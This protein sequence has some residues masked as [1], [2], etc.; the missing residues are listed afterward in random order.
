MFFKSSVPSHGLCLRIQEQLLYTKEP[1]ARRGWTDRPT[2]RPTHRR[3]PP[4]PAR[5]A[6]KGGVGGR[7]GWPPPPPPPARGA[8]GAGQRDVTA[9]PRLPGRGQLPRS[10]GNG[11]AP[12][13]AGCGAR[14]ELPKEPAPRWQRSS[15]G[16]SGA[17]APPRPAA[18]AP[19]AAR[20][21]AAA[22]GGRCGLRAARRCS[23]ARAGGGAGSE[24]LPALPAHGCPRSRKVLG[25]ERAPLPP[26]LR[27][28]F[29][30]NA[31]S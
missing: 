2:D 17:R 28:G 11:A 19:P 25:E 13:G 8:G 30:G 20:P 7:E 27:L 15:G 29:W 10:W 16:A 5:A 12:A 23:A 22:P 26:V 18:A 6:D 14:G 24:R 4:Q 31:L 3:C 1:R 21:P 9:A